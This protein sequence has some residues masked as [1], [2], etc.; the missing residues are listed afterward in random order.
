MKPLI[1][2]N[3]KVGQILSGK[4][5]NT[6]SFGAFIELESGDVGLVHIS[7]ISENYVKSV[8]DHLKTGDS[9]KVKVLELLENG[10][11]SLS[12]KSALKEDLN[13]NKHN[14]QNSEK[15]EQHKKN[16]HTNFHNNNKKIIKNKHNSSEKFEDM[17]SK[18]M[19]MSS[20]KLS[21]F[22]KPENNRRFSKLRDA[23]KWLIIL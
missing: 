19:K 14:T 10:K 17:V 20:E 4:V 22:A 9:V 15:L 5:Q 21:D 1:E 8:N 7:E 11:I 18:F 13:L 23:K 3:I 2:Q 12:I 6:T 16:I